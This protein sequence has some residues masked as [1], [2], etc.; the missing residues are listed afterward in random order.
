MAKTGIIHIHS[1][2]SYDGRQSLEEI[3]LFARKRGYCFV[4]M[5]EHSDTFTVFTIVNDGVLIAFGGGATPDIQAT[6][7]VTIQAWA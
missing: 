6:D 5:T 2:L 3:A 7:I 4:G 1:N